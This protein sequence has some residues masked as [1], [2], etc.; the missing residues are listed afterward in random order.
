M[1][2]V[3]CMKQREARDLKCAESWLYEAVCGQRHELWLTL[4]YMKLC[5]DRELNCGDSWLHEAVCRKSPQMCR[6]LVI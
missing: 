6:H 4:H 3:R 2:T 1:E 5:I